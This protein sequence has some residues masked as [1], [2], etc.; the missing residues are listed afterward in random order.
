VVFDGFAVSRARFAEGAAL[1]GRVTFSL[2]PQSI[3]LH[4]QPPPASEHAALLPGRVVQR[5][6]LGEHW[7]YAVR[8]K[9]GALLL[10]VTA[11]PHEVFEM[12]E[13][14]WLEIDPRQM[15]PIAD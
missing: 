13:S 12:D 9:D 2:R 6:Y 8:P 15:A 3:H 1:A 5:A 7:D 11:R 4:R 10:R 14:V